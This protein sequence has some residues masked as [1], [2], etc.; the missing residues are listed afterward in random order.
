MIKLELDLILECRK[1]NNKGS[2]FVLLEQPDME[3]D[4][5]AGPN[6]LEG[7]LR[8]LRKHDLVATCGRFQAVQLIEH[9]RITEQARVGQRRRKRARGYRADGSKP[10]LPGRPLS[11]ERQIA[12]TSAVCGTPYVLA[13]YVAKSTLEAA[14]ST[15]ERQTS[16]DRESARKLKVAFDREYREQG[17]EPPD[18]PTHWWRYQIG[19][20]EGSGWPDG[21]M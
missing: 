11:L 12:R 20:L 17:V 1:W 3:T 10:G 2:L 21:W 13:L 4:P 7:A 6:E 8:V 15:M 5:Q 19:D 16:I 14:K 9:A 18:A